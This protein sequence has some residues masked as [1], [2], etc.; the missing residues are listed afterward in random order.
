MAY[1]VIDGVEEARILRDRLR[2][3]EQQHVQA[4]AAKIAGDSGVEEKLK[5]LEARMKAIKDAA[6]KAEKGEANGK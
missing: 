5:D 1:E 4:R 2:G 6:G 3:L